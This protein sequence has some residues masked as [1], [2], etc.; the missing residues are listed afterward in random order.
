M[1]SS[2]W[3]G[4]SEAAGGGSAEGATG[5][6]ALAL[7][8]VPVEPAGEGGV[9]G[10][11]HTGHHPSGQQCGECRLPRP[12]HQTIRRVCSPTSAAMSRVGSQNLPVLPPSSFD[13]SV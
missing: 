12:I 11:G 3:F 9:G 7:G 8:V 10:G 4:L 6:D 2:R 1:S 13:E 5:N